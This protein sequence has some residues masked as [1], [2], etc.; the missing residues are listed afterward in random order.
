M[1]NGK[2]LQRNLNQIFFLNRL[3]LQ[4]G[5]QPGPPLAIPAKENA[6]RFPAGRLSSSIV[7]LIAARR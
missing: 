1:N 7:E 6:R 5:D 3:N 4:G 2:M